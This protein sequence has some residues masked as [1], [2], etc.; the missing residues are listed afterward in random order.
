MSEA[1]ELLLVA[2][3]GKIS[4]EQFSD[5]CLILIKRG[6]K[7]IERILELNPQEKVPDFFNCENCC[8]GLALSRGEL[9][10]A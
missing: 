1:I 8:I 10:V 5:L 9:D 2:S 7:Y 6:K 4:G 3:Q